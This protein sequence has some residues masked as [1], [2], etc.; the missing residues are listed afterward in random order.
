MLQAYSADDDLL[1][2]QFF[3]A[4][5]PF[6]LEIISAGTPI[7]YLLASY[8]DSG[9]LGAITFETTPVPLPPAI[10]LLA[11]GMLVVES[12]ARKRRGR[13]AA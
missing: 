1:G 2:D 7:A 11:C 10:A 12:A 3:I 4:N 13:Y 9:L 5:H 6:T 8:G